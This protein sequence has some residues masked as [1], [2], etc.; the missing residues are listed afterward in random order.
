VAFAVVPTENICERKLSSDHSGYCVII[1]MINK[2]PRGY[3]QH[4]YETMSHDQRDLKVA[5]LR[6]LNF[7]SDFCSF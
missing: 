2:N 5:Y 6:N 3:E 4:I 7:Q 1:R